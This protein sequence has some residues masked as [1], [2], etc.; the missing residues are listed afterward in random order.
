MSPSSSAVTF[1][2]DGHWY[3]LDISA[4]QYVVHAVEITPLP[5]APDS[6]AGIINVR[7]R[8]VPV[9]DPR[10]R[11]HLPERELRL[12]DHI[13]LARTTRRCVALVVDAVGGVVK[14]TADDTVPVA[15]ILPGTECVAG[16]VK[17]PDGLILI[18]DLERFLSVDETAQLE[19]ALAT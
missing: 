7:G 11:F 18:H 19:K 10:R 6:V 17:R 2:L 15:A 12:D 13:I 16:V 4:V 14:Y 3:A 8:V 5:R 1:T 9:F